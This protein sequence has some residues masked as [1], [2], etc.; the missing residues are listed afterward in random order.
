MGMLL[1]EFYTLR[2]EST[3][4]LQFG[5]ADELYFFNNFSKISMI[6]TAVLEEGVITHSF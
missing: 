5:W 4:I 2:P 3:L 6:T 1:I